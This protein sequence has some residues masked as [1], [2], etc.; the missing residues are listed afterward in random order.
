MDKL[1]DQVPIDAG[2]TSGIGA[3][4]SRQLALDGAKS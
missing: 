3:G 2:S 1:V 4:I